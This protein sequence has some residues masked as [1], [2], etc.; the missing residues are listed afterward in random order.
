VHLPPSRF[1]MHDRRDE[2]KGTLR[3]DERGR[4]KDLGDVDGSTDL[5]EKL[6]QDP[7]DVA[8]KNV[9]DVLPE[10]VPETD[11]TSLFS[12][13]G[14]KS[15]SKDK[16]TA[17]KRAERRTKTDRKVCE[18]I[19]KKVMALETGKLVLSL[20]KMAEANRV[21]TDLVSEVYAQMSA[22]GY[23]VKQKN[24]RYRRVSKKLLRAA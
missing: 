20:R 18:R 24:G 16:K 21:G 2:R 22:D 13:I 8:E 3:Q 14:T 19:E 1:N 15:E 9:P 6:D 4:R 12:Q 23:V 7:I 5:D 17:K 10:I 11:K